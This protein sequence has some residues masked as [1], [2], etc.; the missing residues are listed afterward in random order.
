ME[1]RIRQSRAAAMAAMTVTLA[2]SVATLLSGCLGPGGREARAREQRATKWSGAKASALVIMDM[3]VGYMPVF[4]SDEVFANIG[5]LVAAARA[6]G[7]PVV[8]VY[9][10]SDLTR[11]DG[12]GFPVAPPLAPAPE[13]FTVTKQGQSAFEGGKLEAFLDSRA[14][15]RLVFCGLASDGCVR[16]SVRASTYAGYLTVVAEDAHT[17]IVGYGSPSDSRRMNEEWRTEA[18]A[19]LKPSVAI[20]FP[21]VR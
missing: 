17:A 15:G 11:P 3:Q 10:D 12:P 13:D 2:L 21:A 5:K 6:A 4:R 1:R 16:E 7:S 14:V 20:A 19:E 8:W 18:R 9:T